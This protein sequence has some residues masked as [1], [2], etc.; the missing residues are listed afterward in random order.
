MTKEESSGSGDTLRHKFGA[1]KLPTMLMAA[2]ISADVIVGATSESKVDLLL[3][4]GVATLLFV[5]I[6]VFTD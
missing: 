5:L 6:Y 1:E 3:L 2:L 4:L